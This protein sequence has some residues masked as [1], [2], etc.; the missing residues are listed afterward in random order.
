MTQPQLSTALEN[1]LQISDTTDFFEELGDEH[2]D[3]K[4]SKCRAFTPKYTFTRLENPL[5]EKQFAYKKGD[6]LYTGRI[7]QVYGPRPFCR[8]IFNESTKELKFLFRPLNLSNMDTYRN[9]KDYTWLFS[10]HP[11]S[12]FATDT[13]PGYRFKSFVGTLW[14]ILSRKLHQ[15]N[16]DGAKIKYGDY[17]MLQVIKYDACFYAIQSDE[18][19]NEYHSHSHI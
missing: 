1:F 2:G 8:V 17:Y 9:M 7:G 10:S 11:P 19:P 14:S 6:W 12:S 18:L 5:E 4:N 3:E 13:K 16:D 15:I